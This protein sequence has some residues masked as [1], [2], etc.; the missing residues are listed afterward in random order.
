MGILSTEVEVTLCSRNIKWYENLGYEIPRRIDKYGKLTVKQGTKIMVKVEDLPQGSN[1]DID[2]TCD[3]CNKIYKLDYYKYN[4]TLH[5]GK[6]Y[7]HNCSPKMLIS[8]ERH[9]LW[10]SQKT[11]EERILGRRTIGGY[12]DFIKNVLQRDKYICCRCNCTSS[13]LNVH[14]LNSYDWFIEGRTD[15]KNA[16]TLCDRCHK[17]FHLL[18][19][20][21]N[22]TKEQF[23]EWMC[24]SFDALKDYSGELNTSRKVYCLENDTVYNGIYEFCK[25]NNIKNDGYAYAICNSNP[26]DSNVKHKVRAKS[27]HGLHILWYDKYINMTKDDFDLYLK[28]IQYNH[29]CKRVICVN[30]Q[31][32]FDSMSKAAKFYKVSIGDIKKC[33]EGVKKYHKRRDGVLLSWEYYED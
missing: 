32:I 15:V 18:Y 21:G 2:V 16:V 3:N 28:D 30:D 33:C 10:D 4:I 20:K 6:H 17:N 5:D 26:Y 7:C 31:K 29:S 12:V 13:K 9:Y 11:E 24:F 14:H 8:G 22:N 23:E 19:G 27:V 25:L 1:V